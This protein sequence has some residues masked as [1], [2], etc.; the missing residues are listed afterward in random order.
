M[1][2]DHRPEKTM[3]A[4]HVKKPHARYS[5]ARS[6]AHRLECTIEEAQQKSLETFKR[7]KEQGLYKMYIPMKVYALKS[8]VTAQ[9]FH[10]KHDTDLLG[11]YQAVA[12]GGQW[13]IT[14]I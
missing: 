8:G 4:T 7:M 9:K 14:K 3:L 12:R 10:I 2:T 6:K 5:E 13:I 1:R 11:R